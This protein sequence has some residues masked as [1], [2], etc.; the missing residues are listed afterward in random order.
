MHCWNTLRRKTII[1]DRL[2]NKTV[3]TIRQYL[4]SSGTEKGHKKSLKPL[5]QKEPP[6]S[7]LFSNYGRSW[8]R[9][10]TGQ[11]KHGSESPGDSGRAPD[12]SDSQ[13]E[14]HRPNP[15]C[16]V[17]ERARFMDTP[18][19]KEWGDA[20]AFKPVGPAVKPRT[21]DARLLLLFATHL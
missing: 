6:S 8:Q 21:F 14:Q 20:L 16:Y 4:L 15:R 17:D 13:C 1:C 2:A 18:N 10:L 19:T 9:G 12:T 3:L 7:G 11:S 5:Y